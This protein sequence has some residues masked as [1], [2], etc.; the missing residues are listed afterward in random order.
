M[1]QVSKMICWSN[2]LKYVREFIC[3][4]RFRFFLCLNL[5]VNVV[6]RMSHCFIIT[7]YNRTKIWPVDKTTFENR[8]SNNE[9]TWETIQ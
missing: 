7:Y 3:S 2:I 6:S 1:L 8:P 4:L 5:V 9:T